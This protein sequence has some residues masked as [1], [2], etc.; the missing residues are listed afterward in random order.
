MNCNSHCNSTYEPALNTALLKAK[1]VGPLPLLLVI[2]HLVHSAEQ[3]IIKHLVQVHCKIEPEP[4]LWTDS[5]VSICSV[6]TVGTVT[7]RWRGRGLL[8]TNSAWISW[9]LSETRMAF[10]SLPLLAFCLCRMFNSP[11][12]NCIDLSSERR[13][14]F[15]EKKE[16]VE[17][18]IN[19][20]TSYSD[21]LDIPSL[22]NPS[23]FLLVQYPS[24]ILI[25]LLLFFLFPKIL[26]FDQKKLRFF[27]AASKRSSIS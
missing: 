21:S 14:C 3:A 26:I 6:K 11:Y 15:F 12:Y 20:F 5:F 16:G 1:Q 9:L 24:S 8:S 4:D 22:Q 10:V 2:M 18:L 13:G 17:S 27:H 7:S 25:S 23:S 19:E